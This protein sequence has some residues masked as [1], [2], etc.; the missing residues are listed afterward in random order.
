MRNFAFVLNIIFCFFSCQKVKEKKYLP[1]YSYK[2]AGIDKFYYS[3]SEI[4]NTPVI[5]LIKPYSISNI[6]SPREW[7]LDTYATKLINE[8]GGGI[9]PIINFNCKDNYIYGYKPFEEDK[10]DSEFNSP[11]KW[12]IIDVHEKKLTFFDKETDFKI[13]IKKLNLPETFLNPDEVFEQ[14]KNDPVLPWF[15]D[16]IKRQLEEVRA[17]K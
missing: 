16:D 4:G 5:P 7:Y 3:H 6:G 11:E 13:A 1:D 2:N 17:K 9:S 15:P 12:F 10:E 8:L 14:Y